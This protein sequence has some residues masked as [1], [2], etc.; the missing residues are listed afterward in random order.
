M[1]QFI[2]DFSIGCNDAVLI[3]RIF[4]AIEISNFS[5]SFFHHQVPG[6][7]VPGHEFVFIEAV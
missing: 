6:G 4:I 3:G 1:N 5:A 2:M 7:T